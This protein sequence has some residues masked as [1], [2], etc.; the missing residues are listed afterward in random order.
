VR[1]TEVLSG[2]DEDFCWDVDK[3]TFIKISGETPTKY[4][5]SHYNRGLYRI[6]PSDIYNSCFRT[7]VKT[8]ISFEVP[9]TPI[10]NVGGGA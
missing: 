8:K 2:D 3:A 1:E 4:D 5:R 6:Y 9:E 7:K 10:K